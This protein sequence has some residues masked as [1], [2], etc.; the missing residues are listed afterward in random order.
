MEKLRGSVTLS[1]ERNRTH[2]LVLN[3]TVKGFKS[4]ESLTRFLQKEKSIRFIDGELFLITPDFTVVLEFEQSLS[5]REYMEELKSFIAEC[6]ND[7]GLQG[8]LC[9]ITLKT[10][11]ILS[12]KN[13]YPSCSEYQFR[14]AATVV[15]VTVSSGSGG[16]KA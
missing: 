1:I 12:V 5:A 3:I 11:N 4:V 14:T 9:L 8:V 13:N 2:E 6:A 10:S 16:K 7:K 15:L